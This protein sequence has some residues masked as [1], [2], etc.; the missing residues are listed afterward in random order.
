MVI[1]LLQV[2]LSM[3]VSWVK[4][5]RPSVPVD[6]MSTPPERCGCFDVRL[7]VCICILSLKWLIRYLGGLTRDN[8][9][10]EA[11]GHLVPVDSLEI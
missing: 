2:Q 8:Q 1:V 6:R 11:L 7:C 9:E 3:H 4:V 5:V 10:R